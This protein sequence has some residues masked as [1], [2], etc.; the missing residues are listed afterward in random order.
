M[1]NYAVSKGL[2][3]HNPAIAI[4]AKSIGGVEIPRDRCLSY[5]EIKALWLYLDD[6]TEHNI[7]PATIAGLKVLLLTGVRT[8]SLIKAEW[9]EINFDN[10]LWTIPP[11][12]LKLKKTEVRKPHKV[13]LT[14]FVKDLFKE[15]KVLSGCSHVIP[16]RD[17]TESDSKPANDKLF[18]RVIN[19]S[20]GN[21]EGIEENFNAH[22]F[23]AT[24]STSMADIGIAPHITELALGHKLPKIMAT[25][26]KH[27]YLPERKEALEQWSDKIEMLV[28]N[29]NV[30]LLNTQTK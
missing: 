15:L 2:I 17:S 26:N 9:K 10:S 16:S 4:E 20:R 8:G 29:T 21:I 28:A 19:R 18:S 11:E 22:D 14:D 24:F 12:H 6:R 25:Y 7:H 1:F 27:E 3:K 23:R 30:V 5:E 13:H